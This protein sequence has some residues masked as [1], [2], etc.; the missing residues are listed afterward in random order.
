METNFEDLL[1]KLGVSL[2]SIATT[3][4]VM[5]DTFMLGEFSCKPVMKIG[6][7]FG[8]GAG[9][10]ENEAKKAGLGKGAAAGAGVGMTPMGFLVSSGD[11]ISYIPTSPQSTLQT[12]F[13]QVPSLID[14]LVDL[15]N[16][17]KDKKQE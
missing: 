13:D 1:E 16:N 5:G 7:G 14:K 3:D 4:T 2:K 9:D 10:G 8:S 12:V 15:K 6:L 11:R 17:L